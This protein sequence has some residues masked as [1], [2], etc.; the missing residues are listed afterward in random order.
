MKQIILMCVCVCVSVRERERQRE[1]ERVRDFFYRVCRWK[2]ILSLE[3]RSTIWYDLPLRHV[4]ECL[5]VGVCTVYARVRAISNRFSE[6]RT[7][8]GGEKNELDKKPSFH[9]VTRNHRC[10]Y[11]QRLQTGTRESMS[12]VTYIAHTNSGRG[13]K[14]CT[15]VV[16]CTY[17]KNHTHKH[18][19]TY[20]HADTSNL[21]RYPL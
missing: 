2:D 6:D 5:C 12:C 3:R 15:H 10:V 4:S 8:T 16:I 18:T 21:Q 20:I 13:S 7:T 14:Q 11:V 9:G 1:R 19:H 17:G